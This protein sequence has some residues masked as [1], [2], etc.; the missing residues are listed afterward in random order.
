MDNARNIKIILAI[1]YILIIIAFLWF[2]L[3]NFSLKDLTNY[4]LIKANRDRLDEF[5]NSNIFFSVTI[6]FLFTVLWVMLLGFGSPIFLIG[7]FIFGK[8]IGTI[9]VLIGLST[10]ATLLYIVANFILKDFIYSKFN[11]KFYFLVDKF[12]KNEFIYF[13]IYR[14]IGGIPFFIQNLL[15]TLF[16]IKIK[17]YFFGSIVGLA[18]QIFIGVSLGTGINNLI[19]KNDEM[20]TIFE[21][22]LEPEIYIPIIAFIVI[23]VVAFIVRKNF[24]KS[25]NDA[26]TQN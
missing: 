7:G 25:D 19:D 23:L 6:F 15:P 13:V 20:P 1:I 12:K 26:P 8:W 10:G 4:E 16:N 18:P 22:F 21:M 2:F 5:K 3:N 24:F 14:I 17:N 9:V 11:S